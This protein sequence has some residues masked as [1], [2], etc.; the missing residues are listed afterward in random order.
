MRILE[1]AEWRLRTHWELGIGSG[2]LKLGVGSWELE[3]DEEGGV[4]AQRD[5]PP[6]HCENYQ[7]N[8]NMICPSRPP[9][10]NVLLGSW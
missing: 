4:D 6:S 3:V 5:R 9:G 1:V 7:L 2:E 8:L 10:S